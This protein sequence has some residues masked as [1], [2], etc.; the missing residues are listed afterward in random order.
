M[1]LSLELKSFISH[2]K[3]GAKDANA[4]DAEFAVVLFAV[5]F[6]ILLA[7]TLYL[8]LS[9]CCCRPLSTGLRPG[10][11]E[12]QSG[13]GAALEVLGKLREKRLQRRRQRPRR[14]GS[15]PP[16]MRRKAAMSARSIAVFVLNGCAWAL[17]AAAFFSFQSSASFE[18][19]R[20]AAPVPPH[21]VLG[22]SETASTRQVR[23]AYRKLS[24]RF[25]PDSLSSTAS[26]A[27]RTERE[28]QFRRVAKAYEALT[29]PLAMENYRKCALLE[30][31]GEVWRGKKRRRVRRE[32]WRRTDSTRRRRQCGRQAGPRRWHG[33]AVVCDREPSARRGAL[34]PRR[35]PP[36]YAGRGSRGLSGTTHKDIVRGA[37]SGC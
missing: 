31:R 6:S 18:A 35:G 16:A 12:P 29:V 8:V 20:E 15:D 9:S 27:E 17:L 21:E 24:R 23:K 10:D 2:L 13:R 32:E 3:M 25:H 1:S 22:V 5:S 36:S 19:L 11:D 28:A 26:G 37:A 7:W 4:Q 34:E 30:K 33:K 14:H